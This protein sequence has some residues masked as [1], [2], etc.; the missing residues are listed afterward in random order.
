MQPD[1]G[2]CAYGATPTVAVEDSDYAKKGEYYCMKECS[3]PSDCG[4][5]QWADPKCGKVAG[6]DP[7]KNY[8][9]CDFKEPITNNASKYDSLIH[10]QE[11]IDFLKNL[12]GNA[13]VNMAVITGA[14]VPTNEMDRPTTVEECASVNGV[15]CGASRYFE[16][17]KGLDKY[18]LDSICKADYG[19]TL[20]DIVTQLI[21]E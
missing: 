15:A 10:V 1:N 3:S 7:S 21:T 14:K 19:Q 2:N 5:F 6:F 12:K 11:F 17:A 18:Y 9:Y 16:V 4:S 13:G 20:V 8:C